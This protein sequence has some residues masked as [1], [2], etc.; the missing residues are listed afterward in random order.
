ML[1]VLVF[2]SHYASRSV[3]YYWDWFEAI[4]SYPGFDVDVVSTLA[5]TRLA[6]ELLRR[7]GRSYDLIVFPYGFYYANDDRRSRCLFQLLGDVRGV[8]VY[9]LENEYRFLNRKMA[10]ATMLDADYVTTQVPKD[11]ADLVYSPFLPPERIVS[12]PHGL[13]ETAAA[14]LFGEFGAQVRDIDLDFTGDPYGFYLGHQERYEMVRFF[15]ENADRLGLKVSCNYGRDRKMER[16]EWIAHLCRCKGVLHQESGGDFFETNDSTRIKVA[17]Y[18]EAHPAATF[19]EVFE[20]F[21]R[22]YPRPMKVRCIS[23]RHFDAIGARTCQIMF[24]GR[25]NDILRAGEHYLALNRDFGNVD[26]VLRQFRDEGYRTEMVRRTY[27]YARDGH[28]L[29]HRVAHLLREIGLA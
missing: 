4:C 11:V 14:A 2:A 24:P 5:K 28:T 3:S 15:V 13:N 16:R 20:L 17:A 27:E 19:E 22:N 10:Y 23:S 29:K 9:F 1:R 18:L 21:F 12:L 8:R 6:F 7:R 25:Y 26:D